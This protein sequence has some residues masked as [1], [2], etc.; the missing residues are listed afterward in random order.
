MTQ[1]RRGNKLGFMIF[2]FYL[3]LG[4]R[5]AY[6]LLYFVSGYYL[7]FDRQTVRANSKYINMR[8]K[9][10]GVLKR[11]W[12]IYKLIVATGKNLIDLRQL[13]KRPEKIQFECDNEP[14]KKIISRK[15]GLIIMTAHIGNWQV[16]MRKLPDFGAKMNII[17]LPEENPAVSESLKIDHGEPYN[18]NLIDPQKGMESVL[19]IMQELSKGN[20]VSIM[21]DRRTGDEKNIS[22][23]FFGEKITLPI[24]PFLIAATADA[25]A[26][27]LLTDK[28]AP[29]SYALEMTNLIIDDNLKNKDEKI[30]ALAEK[31]IAAIEEFLTRNPYDWNST[32]ENGEAKI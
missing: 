22:L 3:F 19:E 31:Y 1:R 21:G 10:A 29:C 12:H 20:I 14:I 30:N 27:L 9:E 18:L 15:K 5:H 13:E 7:L 2:D 25:P 32:G 6:A 26:I 17:M 23:E 24:G 8:F 4:I 16:M 11:I 28:K